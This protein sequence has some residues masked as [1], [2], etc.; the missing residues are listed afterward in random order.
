MDRSA[1]C[2][3]RPGARKWR[4]YDHTSNK[5]SAPTLYTPAQDR[6][7]PAVVLHVV[8][9]FPDLLAI[10]RICPRQILSVL[11]RHAG[12]ETGKPVAEL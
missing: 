3:F 8:A 9:G 10:P 11:R 4:E 12:F 5:K 1:V 7:S 6:W 2:A